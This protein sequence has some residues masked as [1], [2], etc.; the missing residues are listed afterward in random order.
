MRLA[1]ETPVSDRLGEGHVATIEDQPPLLGRQRIG[2]FVS[3]SAHAQ[4]NCGPVVE[5]DVK[6]TRSRV[7]GDEFNE[8]VCVPVGLHR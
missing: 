7:L 8:F 6:H 5:R 4:V 2:D 1:L 3:T